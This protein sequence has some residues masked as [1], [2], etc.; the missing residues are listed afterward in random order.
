MLLTNKVVLITGAGTGIGAAA[1]SLF[2]QNGA[3]VVIADYDVDAGTKTTESVT[4]EGG[5]ALF[6]HC[7]MTDETSVQRCM[8]AVIARYGAIHVLYNNVGGSTPADGPVTTVALD[9]FWRAIKHDVYSTFLGSRF[10][11]PYISDSG[12]GSVINTTSYTA[13]LGTAGRDC[14]TC[15]KGAIISLTRSMAVEFAPANIRVNAI[16]P[17]AVDTERLRKFVSGNPDHP[18]FDPRNRH[19]RPEVA[20]HMLGIVQPIDVANAALYLASDLS[21]RVTGTVLDVDSGAT[22]W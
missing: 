5:D 15:A 2:A 18:T 3:K 19:R 22:V 4:A 10:A 13:K 14:Y 17:G 21:T 8:E 20:S 6:V 11:I 1:A 9:E 16:S 12:G 7:D